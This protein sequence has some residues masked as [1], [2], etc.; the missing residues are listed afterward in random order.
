MAHRIGSW[1]WSRLVA[2][3]T[4]VAIAGGTVVAPA[5]T[6][7]AASPAP[8]PTDAA[9]PVG[10][11]E[12]GADAAPSAVDDAGQGGTAP[13][14]AAGTP[15]TTGAP[16]GDDP[17]GVGDDPED[18]LANEGPAE[19]APATDVTVPPPS[20]YGQEPY[21]P[22]QILWS[23]VAEAERKLE[24]SREARRDAVAQA[25]GLRRSL[26]R[27]E[28]DRKSLDAETTA[29]IHALDET[30]ERFQE[31]AIVGFRRFG[32]GSEP[33]PEADTG[34]DRGADPT[35]LHRIMSRKRRSRMVAKA[36]DFDEDDLDR[37][38]RLRRDLDGD[39]RSVLDRLRLVSDYLGEA[40]QAAVDAEADIR[41]AEI[42]YEAFRAG[43][44]IFIDGVVFP[45]AGDHPLPLIDSFGF[46]RMTGTP[47]E[48]WH[49]GIDLFAPRGTP[50]VATERG[51]ITRV[52]SGRLGGLK[53]WLKG[54]SG[55]E[56]YYA[57]LDSFANGLVDGKLVEAGDL[58]G[59]VGNTGNA[60]GT[61]PHL[62]MQMHPDGGRPVNPYPLLKVVSDLDQAA[63]A[64]GTHPGW[65]HAPV[66]VDRAPEPAP[67]APEPEGGEAAG[68]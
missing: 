16:P 32:S 46:P 23:N 29:T 34:V 61:P 58:L 19:E 4:A 41:Q 6:T 30:T 67:P 64:A 43:S 1:R 24:T 31:R 66:V 47:D 35:E 2:G 54:E 53:L 9:G 12:T 8:E 42:E 48:H 26:K 14:S 38:G 10:Q 49:E 18:P 55:T 50:L 13:G 28:A 3:L 51:I 68:G 62:H 37:L 65:A 5:P 20:T 56:W 44:E 21:K 22:A 33:D 57:H 36:L 45:I 15:P 27:L 7:A 40:E 63:I 17:D 39:A 11:A 60:V 25:R 52:G 59:Y